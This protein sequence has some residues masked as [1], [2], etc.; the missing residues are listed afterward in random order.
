MTEERVIGTPTMKYRFRQMLGRT[1][2]RARGHRPTLMGETYTVATGPS[3]V[4]GT[5][6]SGDYQ[7]PLYGRPVAERSEIGTG[8]RRCWSR[9][10]D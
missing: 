10:G 2:C 6:T 4:I 5:M 7:A 1:V 8:C 9:I 3:Q